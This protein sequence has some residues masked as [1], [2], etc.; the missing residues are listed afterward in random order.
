M[1]TQ[2]FDEAASTEIA[3]VYSLLVL[4]DFY[5]IL[6]IVVTHRDHHTTAYSQLTNQRF[7]YLGRSGC[8]DNRIKR[9]FIAPAGSSVRIAGY[10]VMIS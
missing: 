10:N 9:A 8:H 1:L 5:Q 7:R 4:I 3:F 2:E 6:R